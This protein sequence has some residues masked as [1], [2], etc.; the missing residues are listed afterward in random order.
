[1]QIV[2]HDIHPHKIAQRGGYMNQIDGGELKNL[3][4]NQSI[5]RKSSIGGIKYFCENDCRI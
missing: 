5:S 3:R 1:M 2:K 4:E